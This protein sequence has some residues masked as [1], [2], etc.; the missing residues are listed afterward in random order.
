MSRPIYE[1]RPQRDIASLGYG[2]RQLERRPAPLSEAGA[3]PIWV[4]ITRTQDVSMTNNA[5]VFPFPDDNNNATQVSNNATGEIDI[6]PFTSGG[7]DFLSVYVFEPSIITCEYSWA[8]GNAT[9]S[10][11]VIRT[12]IRKEVI[13]NNSVTGI[14]RYEYTEI[15]TSFLATISAVDTFFVTQDDIDDTDPN[16]YF[17]PVAIQAT[18]STQNLTASDFQVWRLPLVPPAS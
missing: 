16:N 7:N 3:D 13:A 18:G 15:T 2:R 8:I 11:T 4:R 9:A 14:N 1:P 17:V 12:G 10:P 6:L 5:L